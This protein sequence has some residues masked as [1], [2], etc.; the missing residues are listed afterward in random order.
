MSGCTEVNDIIDRFFFYK[1]ST[2]KLQAECNQAERKLHELEKEKVQ[3]SEGLRV[4]QFT[5]TESQED[6]D[7]YTQQLRNKLQKAEDRV[8]EMEEKYEQ[9]NR[10]IP[11]V[12]AGVWHL[13]RLLD[14]LGLQGA[15]TIPDD[16]KD[17]EI[18]G[19]LQACETNFIVLDRYVA[20]ASKGNKTQRSVT[21]GDDLSALNPV[22]G[23]ENVRI[24]FN[25][26]KNSEDD[27]LD[28]YPSSDF[29][30]DWNDTKVHRT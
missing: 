24:V 21:P 18:S 1:Q 29:E 12:R 27:D 13:G 28:I 3:L 25:E 23:N 19:L 30:D 14:G 4:A 9:V 6:T 15:T 7:S 10:V 8:A 5:S 26:D 11:S 16:W 20:K 17:H 22:L 2:S